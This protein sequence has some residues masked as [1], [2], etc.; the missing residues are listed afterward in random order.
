[1]RAYMVACDNIPLFFSLYLSR[2]SRSSIVARA[3][4]SCT[5]KAPVV[6]ATIS[7][8]LEEVATELQLY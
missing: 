3:S 4:R 1:M 8:D 7:V 5:S 2:D 6:Q